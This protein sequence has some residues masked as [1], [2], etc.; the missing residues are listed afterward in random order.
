M[1]LHNTGSSALALAVALA[2][3]ALP[4]QAIVG[5]ID[6]SAFGQVSSGVLVS[7]NWV[8]T[9]RHVGYSVGGTYSDGY[10]SSSI[11]AR[12]DFGSGDFPF[13]D[14]AL[15]RLSDAIAA[16]TLSV[17][18]TQFSAG[19]AYNF[20]ATIVTGLNQTPRGYAWTAVREF[21]PQID[22]DGAGPQAAVD[23]NWLVTYLDGHETPY[24]ENGDSG[25]ALFLGQVLDA[26][27]PLL[28]ITSEI[29]YDEDANGVRSNY[30]SAFVDLASFRSW[31][32]TT[33]SDD[34]SDGQMLQ[35]VSTAVPEP[36]TALLAVLGLGTL[37]LRRRRG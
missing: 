20:D 6:T 2:A 37:A 26:S 11:A 27:T 17:N 24:V 9:A 31:I 32:D 3:A 36:S 12:Y 34:L 25:G 16:P 14:L 7:P 5:G 18:A 21:L 13:G 30:R 15:L 1:K 10:G 29:L 35:W 22:P 23:V 4:A 28:G 8:L 33:M 19:T